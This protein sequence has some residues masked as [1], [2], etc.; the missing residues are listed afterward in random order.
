MRKL[1]AAVASK[2]VRSALPWLAWLVGAL[3]VIYSISEVQA[4]I[5]I[6]GP[7]VLAMGSVFAFFLNRQLFPMATIDSLDGFD[8]ARADRARDRL[9]LLVCAAWITMG[10][11]I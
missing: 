1:P 11:L 10:L 2:E 7:A 5:F 4:E 8:P 6:L 9:A 3:V